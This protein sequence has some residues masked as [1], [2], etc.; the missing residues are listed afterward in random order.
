[1]DST[2]HVWRQAP[3]LRAFARFW[4]GC[5]QVVFIVVMATQLLDADGEPGAPFLTIL[6]FLPATAFFWLY[7]LRPWIA[8][9][10]DGV[11]SETRC[12]SDASGIPT[13]LRPHPATTGLPFGHGQVEASSR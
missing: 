6:L 3:V 8:A 10:S 5:Y 7:I 4:I 1:M 11:T 9:D 12:R 13:S 2:D